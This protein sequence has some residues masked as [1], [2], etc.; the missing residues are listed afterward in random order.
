MKYYINISSWNL[1][2]SFVTESLSPFAFYAR[3]NFGNNLSRYISSGTDKINYLVLSTIDNG[4]DYSIEIDSSIVNAEYIKPIKGLSTK[5]IYS[6]TI[7]YKKGSVR[8]RFGNQSL[9][10]TFEAESQIL[11]EVKCIE[12]YKED[13]YV[14]TIKEKKT[15]TTLKKMGEPFSFEQEGF[16]ESDNKLNIIKGAIVGYVRGELTS[17]RSEDL[18]LMSQIKDIKNSFTGLHTT[19]MVN[20]TEVEH[21]E[22]LLQKLYKCKASYF[23]VNKEKSNNFDVLAHIFSEIQN[24]ALLK[25]SEMRQYSSIMTANSYD[26]LILKKQELEDQLIQIENSNN[27]NDLREELQSIKDQEKQIGESQGKKRVY[28]KKGS[29]EYE[30]KIELKALILNFEDGNSEYQSLRRE[31][32]LCNQQIIDSQDNKSQYDN[33]L[34]ALFNRASDIINDIIKKYESSKSLNDVKLNTINYSNGKLSISSANPNDAELEYFNVLLNVILTQKEIETISDTYILSLIEKSANKYKTFESAKT[35]NGITI[36]N[37][38]R[39]Y[40]KY[41]SNKVFSFD[42]PADMPVLQSIM[43]FFIKPYGY[44]Q[45]ERYVLNKRYTEKKYAFMLWAACN[46]YAALPK[47]FTTSLYQDKMNYIEM[48]SLIDE[49]RHL[50]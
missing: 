26:S 22:I 16:I 2:E 29:F 12:K 10:E 20:N 4:G 17:S 36:I 43:S 21:P 3:R 7:Y 11:F 5:F 19:I 44:D 45:I 1:L 18:E 25:N 8:F 42:I 24:L 35:T 41:K 30:R 31:L 50:L 34:S 32:D 49:I 28:F 13:F 27:I 48:D 9:L 14:C 23:K 15:S 6:N 33:T 37:T 47:T 39:E 38:L 46:G 40:W